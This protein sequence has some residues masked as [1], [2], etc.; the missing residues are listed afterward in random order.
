M[1]QH[2]CHSARRQCSI[3][4]DALLRARLQALKELDVARQHAADGV[5][6]IVLGTPGL[7]FGPAA[8]AAASAAVSP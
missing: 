1:R 4:P 3:T 8:A 7:G 2:S 6:L 5:L